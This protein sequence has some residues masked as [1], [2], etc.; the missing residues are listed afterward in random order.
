MP[1]ALGRREEAQR[2]A[3]LVATD[4]RLYNEEAVIL[5]RRQ[6]DLERR[7]SDLLERGRE[8]FHRRFPELGHEGMHMLHEAYIQVL[9]AGDPA[10]LT[11]PREETGE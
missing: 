8:V 10:L 1:G 9:A 5:G 2:F 11:P 4:I 3:R 7:L 6:G